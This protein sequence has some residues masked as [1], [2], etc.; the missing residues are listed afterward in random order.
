MISENE[1]S[2]NKELQL[3]NI[4]STMYFFCNYKSSDSSV[5]PKTHGFPNVVR[6]CFCLIHLF[7]L[8]Q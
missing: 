3:N 2:N 8:C 6:V 4:L 1:K 5:K 7:F